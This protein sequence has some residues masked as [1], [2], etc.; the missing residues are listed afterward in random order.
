MQWLR[1]YLTY[2]TGDPNPP[3][4]ILT[5][6]SDPN[7]NG[8]LSEAARQVLSQVEHAIQQVHYINYDQD[9]QA[10]ILPAKFALQWFCGKMGHSYECIFLYRQLRY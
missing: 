10:S 6:D 7:S 9:W 3:C 1:P 8:Q 4:E 5:G 2:S